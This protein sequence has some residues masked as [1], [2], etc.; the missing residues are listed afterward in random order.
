LNE[1]PGYKEIKM[2]KLVERNEN[3]AKEA[4]KDDYI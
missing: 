3:V 4:S 2:R 1:K